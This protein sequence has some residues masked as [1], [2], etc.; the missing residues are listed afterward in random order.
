MNDF[1]EAL[2]RN[3]FQPCQLLLTHDCE[4]TTDSSCNHHDCTMISSTG[5]KCFV[6]FNK[7][8]ELMI[9]CLYYKIPPHDHLEKFSYLYS[10]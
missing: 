5:E 7:G 6:P 2:K 4:Q 9:L 8:E 1:V 3:Q 10:R